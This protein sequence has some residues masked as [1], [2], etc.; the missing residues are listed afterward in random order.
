MYPDGKH[1]RKDGALSQKKSQDAKTPWD[2]ELGIWD[3]GFDLPARLLPATTAAAPATATAAAAST[4]A[5][6][7]AATETTAATPWRHRPRFVHGERAAAEALLMELRDRVLRVLLG[8]HFD[9]CEA[10]PTPGVT[11]PHDADGRHRAG[12]REQI[13]QVRFID[14]VGEIADIQF[15]AHGHSALCA[16]IDA[17]W[18]RGARSGMLRL[19]WRRMNASL[20]GGASAS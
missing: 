1:D 18:K 11:V 9:K 13:G 16:S 19:G 14:V 6:A 7:T 4:S 3:L 2:L 10:A 15:V 17:L 5:T 20:G 8:R 12:F